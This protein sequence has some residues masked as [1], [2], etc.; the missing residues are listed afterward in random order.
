[1][2]ISRCFYENLIVAKPLHILLDK[3]DEFIQDYGETKY[4]ILFGSE[5]YDAVFDRNRF[6]RNRHLLGV[7][8]GI[9]YVDFHNYTKIK[10]DS[11]DNLPLE[12]T[13]IYA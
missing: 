9:T 3:I 11:D 13:L 2:L 1:M 10:T 4:L 5:K 12:E 6:N 7:K 8:S